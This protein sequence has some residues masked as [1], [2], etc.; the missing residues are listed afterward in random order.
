MDALGMLNKRGRLGDVVSVGIRVRTKEANRRRGV[1][2]RS[3]RDIEREGEVERED[4]DGLKILDSPSSMENA[5]VAAL[6]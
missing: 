3:V 2:V 1:G 6:R 5:S 4:A